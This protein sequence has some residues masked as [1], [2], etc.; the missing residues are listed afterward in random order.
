MHLHIVDKRTFGL[1]DTGSA[2]GWTSG[3][4]ITTKTPRPMNWIWIK[5]GQN[6]FQ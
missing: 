2:T 5:I 1:T 6:F 4:K 3:P